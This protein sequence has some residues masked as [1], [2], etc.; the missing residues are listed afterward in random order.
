MMSLDEKEKCEKEM[1][2]LKKQ[3]D[4]LRSENSACHEQVC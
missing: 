4:C 2:A 3:I 1:P